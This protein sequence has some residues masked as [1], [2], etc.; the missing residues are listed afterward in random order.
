M[1]DDIEPVGEPKGVDYL[2]AI[3]AFGVLVFA[4]FAIIWLMRPIP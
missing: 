3:V 1:T 2:R 4:V